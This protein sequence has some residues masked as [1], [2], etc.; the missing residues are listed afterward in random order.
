MSI[1]ATYDRFDLE[2]ALMACWQTVDDLKLLSEMVTEDALDTDKIANAVMGIEL[3]HEMRCKKTMDI[4]E[5][6][7]SNGEL[8]NDTDID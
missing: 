5:H 7:V 2:Q 3:L 1:K 6:V 8:D 4:F